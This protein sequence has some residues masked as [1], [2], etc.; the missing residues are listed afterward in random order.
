M[1]GRLPDGNMQALQQYPAVVALAACGI[2]VE[3]VMVLND[4]LADLGPPSS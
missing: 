2:P 3:W 4:L 1:A